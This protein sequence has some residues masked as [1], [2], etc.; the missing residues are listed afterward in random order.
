MRFSWKDA[1]H[2]PALVV[3]LLGAFGVFVLLRAEEVPKEFGENG[4]TQARRADFAGQAECASCH[5]EQLKARN[6]GPHKAIV[7]ETCHGPQA[8]HIASGGKEKPAKPNVLTL[9]LNC[10]EKDAAKPGS[11][12]QVVRAEHY[13]GTTCND[14]HQ[15]HQPKM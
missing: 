14:C 4:H 10:H 15:P 6:G 13:A 9:C 8:K 3:F 7:C 1:Q 12:P 11:L 5:D 2:L